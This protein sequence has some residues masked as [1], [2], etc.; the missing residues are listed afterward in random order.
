MS[1]LQANIQ[2]CR[3]CAISNLCHIFLLVWGLNN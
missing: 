1:L 3:T 2:F